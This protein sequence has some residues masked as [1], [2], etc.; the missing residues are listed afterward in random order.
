M[1]FTL[2]T[3]RTLLSGMALCA[4]VVTAYAIF[5][6]GVSFDRWLPLSAMLFAWSVMAIFW[7]QAKF[8]LRGEA[9]EPISRWQKIKYAVLRKL[10]QFMTSLFFIVTLFLL[11][12]SLKVVNFSL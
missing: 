7:I 1:S 11:Y 8:A 10:T 6:G 12:V 5:F 3:L 9:V 2:L 4:L